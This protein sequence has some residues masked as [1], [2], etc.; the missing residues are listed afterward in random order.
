MIIEM[1]FLF[2]TIKRLIR[3][4]KTLCVVALVYLC[5]SVGRFFYAQQ[6]TTPAD[7]LNGKYKD[8]LTVIYRATCQRCQKTIPWLILREGLST[9]KIN[10]VNA[11][12][13]T[14]DQ[15]KELGV[16]VLPTFLYKGKAYN[17]M[18]RTEIEELFEIAK[19]DSEF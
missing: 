6:N 14:Q 9:Q 3:L 11:D 12:E 5:F 17:T 15:R 4:V 19:N 13:F 10:V 7:V 18:D 8:T 16:E 2:R 1:F